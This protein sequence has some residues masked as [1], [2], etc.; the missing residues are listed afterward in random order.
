MA[1]ISN[2]DVRYAQY[3]HWKS[4]SDTGTE[5]DILNHELIV[6]TIIYVKDDGWTGF[7]SYMPH[8]WST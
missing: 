4:L 6:Y 5:F 7:S 3:L 8:W 2:I 1:D